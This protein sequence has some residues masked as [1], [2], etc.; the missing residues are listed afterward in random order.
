MLQ[1]YTED[2]KYPLTDYDDFSI[3]HRLD[4]NEDLSF[5][6]PTNSPHY[7]RIGE[8]TQIDYGDNEWLV[9]KI[10][11]DKF[12][13]SLNFDFLKTRAYCDYKSETKP[14]AYVLEQHLQ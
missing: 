5:I 4:G 1:Y 2:D 14:L 10:D 7:A 13:C 3:K 8:E 12:D 9:K 11:D 6:L